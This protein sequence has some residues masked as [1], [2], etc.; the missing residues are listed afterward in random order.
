MLQ[1]DFTEPPALPLRLFHR[2]SNG[3]ASGN[4]LEEALLHGVCELVERHALH[5]LEHHPDRKVP[6][7]ED[8]LDAPWLRQPIRQIREAGM[9]LAVHDLT[10]EAGIP[11]VMVKLA[12]PDIPN[13]WH[14]SG[15]HPDPA[16]AVS[17]A[18]TEAAQCRLTYISGTR[19]DL[20]LVSGASLA[21][22]LFDEFCEPG[23][24]RNLEE[25]PDLSTASVASD[26]DAVV[27]RLAHNGFKAFGVDLTHPELEIPVA[28]SFVPGLKE[29]SHG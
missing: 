14:G 16:V 2:T 15:C 23:G 20:Q 6:L 21:L 7:R 8:S 25:L 5:L 17:R 26:L 18:L 19:D 24:V 22:R 13:V 3:L 27:E 10:W 1:L 29:Q 9:K 12:A 11:V 4:C 28:V